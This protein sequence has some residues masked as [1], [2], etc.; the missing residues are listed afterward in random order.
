MKKIKIF[1]TIIICL[2]SIPVHF[3]YDIYPN[4][5]TSIFFPVN[6]SIFEHMKIIITSISIA[7]IIEYIIYKHST[8]KYNNFL[9]SIPLISIIGIIFYL[10]I[11]SIINIFINHNLIISITL[12]FITFIICE[13]ISYYILNYK[14]IPNSKIIGI[15][16]LIICYLIFTYLTYYPPKN[17]LF[18]DIQT[19]SYGIN[20]KRYF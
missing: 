11:Y 10:S 9:L 19:N 17:N 5:I 3:V 14:K 7:S 6:E 15:I 12:L 2:L 20:K 18:K 8:I 1:I 13:I 16:L 4:F